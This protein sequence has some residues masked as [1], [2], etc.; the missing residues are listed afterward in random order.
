MGPRKANTPDV[1][2][3]VT[4]A[5]ENYTMPLAVMARSLF[6]NLGSGRC[7]SLIVI[8]GGITNRSK[9][10]LLESW[11]LKQS[12]VRF[13][14][15]SFGGITAL[16]LWGRMTPLTYARILTP[17]YVPPE[18]TKAIFLDSDLLVLQDL[19]RLWDMP[20]GETHLLAVQ[21]PAV[22]F[23]SS[24]DGL[25]RYTELGLA[26]ATPYF[27]AAVM[28]VNVEKWRKD[29]IPSAALRFIEKHGKELNYYDQDA[30]NAV[31]SGKWHALEAR[32]QVQPRFVN[33]PSL[34]LPHLRASA[35]AALVSDP[36]I[37]HFSG[38]LK[39][40]AYCGGSA[41][42]TFFFDY[43]DRTAWA[44]WR[45]RAGMKSRILRFYE[46]RLR[47]WC[48]PVEQRALAWLR[49]RGRRVVPVSGGWNAI[50]AAD[51]R[52]ADRTEPQEA[53]KR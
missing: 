28:L 46:A 6:D 2:T 1:L 39:P 47:A 20:A 32:W 30:L 16:P 33:N 36:W 51:D 3:V 26:P 25:A 49:N 8:D 44:G 7:V 5:D 9:E 11:N 29:D 21:D 43:L 14:T 27:S 19:G 37:I 53:N 35:R 17:A 50:E 15:P 23:V 31:L 24:R 10:R 38:R 42:D 13:V 40:W 4:V 41:A 22:P 12:S 18:C 34:P 45:P 52:S 48:Y